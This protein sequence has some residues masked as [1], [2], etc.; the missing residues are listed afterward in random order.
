MV[1]VME[2]RWDTR[3]RHVTSHKVT[4]NTVQVEAQYHWLQSQFLPWLT[5]C[6]L[7]K[8][9]VW[10]F[11]LFTGFTEVTAWKLETILFIF[12]TFCGLV[13]LGY[14]THIKY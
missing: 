5:L 9:S 7:D 4:I 14:S 2:E 10:F 1:S 3:V 13:R 8:Y 11:Q 6:S 12:Q